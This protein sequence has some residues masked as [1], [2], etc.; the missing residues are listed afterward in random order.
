MNHDK[1][2][3][4]T[5]ENSLTEIFD[6]GTRSSHIFTVFTTDLDSSVQSRQGTAYPPCPHPSESMR[7]NANQAHVPRPDKTGRTN[8]SRGILSLCHF[9]LEFLEFTAVCNLSDFQTYPLPGTQ[10]TVKSKTSWVFLCFPLGVKDRKGTHRKSRLAV[11]ESWRPVAKF[12][13][14]GDEEQVK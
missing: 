2:H 5:T 11:L 14:L 10:N 1:H 7:I 6:T 13:N 8:V 12:A 4:S 3:K 9:A